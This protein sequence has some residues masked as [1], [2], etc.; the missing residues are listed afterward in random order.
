MTHALAS[1]YTYDNGHEVTYT[2]VQPGDATTACDNL[3]RRW[4]NAGITFTRDGD[5]LTR[6]SEVDP[7]LAHTLTVMHL[8]DQETRP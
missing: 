5:S 6:R 1:T 8:D 7:D 4:K 3:A 2:S